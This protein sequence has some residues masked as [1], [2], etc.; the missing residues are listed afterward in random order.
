MPNNLPST[1][2]SMLTVSHL[3]P[4]VG[5]WLM[6]AEGFPSLGSRPAGG[7]RKNPRAKRTKKVFFHRGR[8][9]GDAGKGRNWPSV[10]SPPSRKGEVFMEDHYCLRSRYFT[11]P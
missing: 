10:I 3:A 9:G 7:P 1:L 11:I 6:G 4:T 8:P 2:A 5:R